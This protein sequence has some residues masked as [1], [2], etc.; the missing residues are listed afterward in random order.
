VLILADELDLRR[1]FRDRVD[2][3]HHVVSRQGPKG[4]A[5]VAEP[6]SV[7]VSHTDRIVRTD[8]Q[9]SSSNHPHIVH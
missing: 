5:D 6:V 1:T 3:W 7:R 8:L 4:E 9:S 2:P